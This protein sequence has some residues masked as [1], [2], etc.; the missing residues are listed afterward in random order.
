ML[1][2]LL[3]AFGIIMRL[4]PHPA[5]VTP[6]TAIALVSGMYFRGKWAVLLP[7]L[8]MV[9]SDVFIGW[10]TL[11]LFTWG[12]F[13]AAV[14]IGMLLRRSSA[15]GKIIGGALAGSTFFFLVTNWAV[16]AFTPMYAKTIGGLLASYG[17]GLPFFRNMLLGDVL[18][19]AAL[20]GVFELALMLQRRRAAVPAHE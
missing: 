2:V 18:F 13:A 3:V 16:W 19:T 5:N 1:A 4:V 8:S 14:V 11:V 17:M 12:S 10:H 7:V 20:V 6:L 9:V 15:L